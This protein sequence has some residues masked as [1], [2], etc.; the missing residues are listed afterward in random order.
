MRYTGKNLCKEHFL[1][2]QWRRINRLRVKEEL[3]VSGD[4]VVCACS[5]GKDSTTL[6][7]VLAKICK[8]R[9]DLELEVLSVD[10]GIGGY[11]SRQLKRAREHSREL[12]LPHTTLS[13]KKEFGKSLDE[14]VA[15]NE[16]MSPCA[17][18]GVMRRSL[19]N[20]GAKRLGAT[21]LATAH[22][23]DDE[24]Q[25]VLMNAL[26]GDVRRMARM[27]AKV[28]V[29]DFEGFV[30][31]VK[32]FRLIPEKEVAAMAVLMGLEPD[33]EGS[34]PYSHKSFRGLVKSHLNEIE[35]ESAGVK[36]NLLKFSDELFPI[37][38]KSLSSF[39]VARCEKCGEP[40]SQEVCNLCQILES[41]D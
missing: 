2:T 20:Q 28:G 36:F 17:Y 21:K 34:C 30:P 11:R 8:G 22:N 6:M 15:E 32:P 4:K 1:R 24:A 39:E 31:R 10:E 29:R 7:H 18:C 13:F 14:I 12:G 3:I 16:E 19:L 5:G 38:K 35:K 40:T 27:G 9:P 25:S 37:L 33:F 41:L 26:R 23:A